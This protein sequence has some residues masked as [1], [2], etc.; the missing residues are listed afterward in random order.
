M[1]EADYIAYIELYEEA[2]KNKKKPRP[3]ATMPGK[4]EHSGKPL[5][6]SFLKIM[7]VGSLRK[8]RPRAGRRKPIEKDEDEEDAKKNEVA[9]GLNGDDKVDGEKAKDSKETTVIRNAQA[10]AVNSILANYSVSLHA[11]KNGMMGSKRPEDGKE[12]AKRKK[13]INYTVNSL[14][15]N[16]N[17]IRE[18]TGLKHVLSEYVLY[19]PDRL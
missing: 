9:N 6:F 3:Q 16:N 8:E 11:A 4:I 19:E 7:E 1:S 17:E 2:L 12:E 5:D 18:L 10:P 13:E 14:L 15:L